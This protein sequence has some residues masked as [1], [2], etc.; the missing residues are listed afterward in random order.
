MTASVS[1][2]QTPHFVQLGADP[3]FVGEGATDLDC[4]CGNATLVRGYQPHALLAIAIE[5]ARCGAVT[6]T[7]GLAE[8]EVPPQGVRV[9]ERTRTPMPSLAVLPRDLVLCDRDEFL[10]VDALC[11]PRPAPVEPFE[12][13]AATLATLAAEYDRLGGGR[14]AEHRHVT[15]PDAVAGTSG[16]PPLALAWALGQLAAGVDQPGWSCMANDPDVAA[17][18]QLGAFRE[19]LLT[20]SRHPLFPAMAAGAAAA[21]FSTHA[22]AVFAAARCLAESGNRVGFI[23]PPNVGD[24]FDGFHVETAPTE[25]MPVVVRRFDRFDWPGGQGADSAMVRAAAIDA[26]I[27]A[28]GRLN[29]RQPGLLVLSVGAVRARDDYPIIEG[30]ANVLRARG[31]R[32]RGLAGVAVILPKLSAGARPGQVVFAWRFLPLANPHH[33]G[34]TIRLGPPPAGATP[35]PAG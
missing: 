11:R 26:L 16:L 7:A 4:R 15:R 20:W 12:I 13:S 25:R 19:F 5:C 21:G 29:A 8:G 3:V 27:A 18:A 1:P 2:D 6:T 34:G 31:R 33:T 17:T 23:R 22:L 30:V 35:V 9:V 10:R 14:L 24:P 28:Q 32:H